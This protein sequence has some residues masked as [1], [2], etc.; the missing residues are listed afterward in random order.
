[1]P[2]PSC[3][4][5]YSFV[6]L[7]KVQDRDNSSF[8]FLFDITLAIWGLLRFC[9]NFRIVCFSSEKYFARFKLLVV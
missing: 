3:L 5:D 4:D 6:V 2:V 9:T 7:V 8:G 1:M